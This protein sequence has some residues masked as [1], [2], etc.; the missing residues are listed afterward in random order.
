V[1]REVDVTEIVH[2]FRHHDK[3]TRRINVRKGSIGK[4]CARHPP[5]F[6]GGGRLCTSKA[7]HPEPQEREQ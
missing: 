5:H 6:H 2:P 3:I 1:G 7:V 4:E